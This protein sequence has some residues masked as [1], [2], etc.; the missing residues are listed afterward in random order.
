M[1]FLSTRRQDKR[2]V[3]GRVLVT[4]EPQSSCVINRVCYSRILTRGFSFHLQIEDLFFNTPTRLSALRN[5]SEEYARILDVITK[6]AVH[7]SNV[8]FMCKK[9]CG[10]SHPLLTP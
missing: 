10:S 7:N 8:A 3:H 9:V 5:A 1:E 2:R 6:Y 4:K